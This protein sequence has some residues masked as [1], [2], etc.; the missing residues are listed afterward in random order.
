MIADPQA[1]Q[2]SGRQRRGDV[3]DRQRRAAGV[4]ARVLSPAVEVD[5][6][7]E[8]AV[9]P[10]IAVG[11]VPVAGP[12][13]RLAADSRADH[14]R[15][16]SGLDLLAD[17]MPRPLEEARTLE[18]GHHMAGDRRTAGRELGQRRDLEVTEDRHRDRPRDRRRGHHQHV[19]PGPERLVS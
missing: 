13:R 3:E 14:V 2:R 6:E 1:R 19:R 8:H 4:L 10:V 18:G 15:L 11:A 16:P 17:P 5:V 12:A 9:R 7:V